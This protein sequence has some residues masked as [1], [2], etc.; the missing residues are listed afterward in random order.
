MCGSFGFC[1]FTC[2]K[3]DPTQPRTQCIPAPKPCSKAPTVCDGCSAYAHCFDGGY[4]NKCPIGLYMAAKCFQEVCLPYRLCRAPPTPPSAPPSPP[5][6]PLPPSHPPTASFPCDECT[7]HG[8]LEDL[9]QCGACSSVAPCLSTHEC[10]QS[11][12]QACHLDASPKCKDEPDECLIC[13]SWRDCLL[14]IVFSALEGCSGMPQMCSSRCLPYRHCVAKPLSPPPFLPLSPPPFLPP[15]PS[16]P[17]PLPSPIFT[18]PAGGCHE[19]ACSCYDKAFYMSHPIC[20]ERAGC[21]LAE[22]HVPILVKPCARDDVG[23]CDEFAD[24]SGAFYHG[25]FCYTHAGCWTL[26]AGAHSPYSNSSYPT[27]PWPTNTTP[28]LEGTYCTSSEQAA[29][30]RSV[31]VAMSCLCA[32]LLFLIGVAAFIVYRRYSSRRLSVA[33]AIN[34]HTGT[35]VEGQAALLG[36]INDNA[37]SNVAYDACSAVSFTPPATMEAI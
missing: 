15:P 31:A 8:F 33:S 7:A 34:M 36:S 19:H 23:C 27:T 22:A 26:P 20:Y 4:N 30:W 17:T 14:D 12:E 9:C 3:T 28:H 10:D 11:Y 21:Y 5:A 32:T 24:V 1:S 16:P 2:T 25:V 6:L 29:P 35:A 18:C 13:R 37:V